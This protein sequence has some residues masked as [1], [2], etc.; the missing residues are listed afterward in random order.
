[1]KK[2]ISVLIVAALLL[3]AMPLTANAGTYDDHTWILG[4]KYLGNG[5]TENG[6]VT[7]D[8][9]KL[10]SY[11]A[12]DCHPV[13]IPVGSAN[14]CPY[15][16]PE[17]MKFRCWT[18]YCGS[19]FYYPD[20]PERSREKAEAF[21]VRNTVVSASDVH[22]L[23]YELYAVWE[24]VDAPE[25]YTIGFCSLIPGTAREGDFNYVRA[26]PV[27]GQ[28]V[29][30]GEKATEPVLDSN[31]YT[32]Y[33][34]WKPEGWSRVLV[35]E[36]YE[37]RGWYADPDFS[38]ESLYD[39][40]KPVT[41]NLTLYA[42][43]V[44]ISDVGLVTASFK[45]NGGTTEYQSAN[46]TYSGEEPVSEYVQQLKI[47]KG[48][49]FTIPECLFKAPSGKAFDCW[50][51]DGE[52]YY[53]GNTIVMNYDKTFIANWYDLGYTA[54]FTSNCGVGVQK[55][56]TVK[57]G[58]KLTLP[59]CT[60][61]APGGM[62]FD[63]WQK[64]SNIYKPG[65]Q[66]SITE[67]TSFT[68]I[69]KDAP[70][71]VID[72]IAVTIT[73]PAAGEK[74]SYT[75]SVPDGAGYQ[76]YD[77]NVEGTYKHGVY[78]FDYTDWALIDSGD[79]SYVFEGGKEYRVLISVEPASVLDEFDL[80]SLTATI[81]GVEATVMPYDNG[82]VD[83][84]CVLTCS[85]GTLLGDVDG[86][87]KVD[88]FDASSIQKS[89]AGTSGYANYNTMD[90]SDPKFKVADVDKDG[91]VDVFDAS[92]IQKFIA[93]DTAAKQYGIGEPV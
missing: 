34:D 42:K 31:R 16:A 65:E 51:V 4:F 81:N 29:G 10:V 36:T 74:P 77:V 92:L 18:N 12:M 91:K 85:G 33:Y 38:E 28:Y 53:P 24:S 52:R 11:V 30:K 64:D 57:A 17:G 1:M 45:G 32:Y 50:T 35:E 60:F 41:G 2:V 43:W 15:D 55:D 27:P 62:V 83:L 48:E 40:D 7:Y 20:D 8:S 54:K 79:D 90:K 9:K 49:V 80:D 63:C 69:W 68:A 76:I 58:E 25:T 61:I 88:I 73:A 66:V 13:G 23:D 86:D 78:W 37:F 14:D 3:A 44:L 89:I 82:S 87:G 39:F 84:M 5:G 71:G 46:I 70:R 67:N 59:A 93:G 6:G 72:S 21:Q 26:L 19:V 56:I 47:A 75:A 22:F